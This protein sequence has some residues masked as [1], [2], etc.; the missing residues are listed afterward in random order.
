M[1]HR[2]AKATY[3]LHDI[4]QPTATAPYVVKRVLGF[5]DGLDCALTSL[6]VM[7]WYGGGDVSRIAR[8]AV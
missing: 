6:A 4:I 5:R 8:D 3:F 1:T 2:S 7:L